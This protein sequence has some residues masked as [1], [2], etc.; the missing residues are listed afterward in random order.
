[1]AKLDADSSSYDLVLRREHQWRR[2]SEPLPQKHIDR[3]V[4]E[5]IERQKTTNLY[6]ASKSIP[7]GATSRPISYAKQ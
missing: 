5:A 2:Q 4:I 7:D 3:A 6:D 1:M